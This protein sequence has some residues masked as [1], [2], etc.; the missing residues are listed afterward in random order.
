MTT[1]MPMETKRARVTF[2]PVRSDIENDVSFSEAFE[3]PFIELDLRVPVINQPLVS[4]AP[5]KII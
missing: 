2:F 4:Y 5:V 3:R 1:V